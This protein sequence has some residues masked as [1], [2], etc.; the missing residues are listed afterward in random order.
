MNTPQCYVIRTAPVVLFPIS[1]VR[2][3]ALIAK[4]EGPRVAQRCSTDLES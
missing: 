3:L 2:S 4:V 1:G